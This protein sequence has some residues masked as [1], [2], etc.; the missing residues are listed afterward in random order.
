M[1]FGPGW[2]VDSCS[3]KRMIRSHRESN[4]VRASGVEWKTSGR[5]EEIEL[6]EAA[7]DGE[8]GDDGDVGSRD[9]G[10]N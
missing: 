7:S 2:K 8:V 1:L 4:A 3:L 5:S 9:R 6:V 10:D